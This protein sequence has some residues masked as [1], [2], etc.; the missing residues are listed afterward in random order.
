MSQYEITYILRPLLE[1]P[2][3]DEQVMHFSDVVKNNGGQISNAER[4]GKKRLAYE[5]QKQREGHY[6]CMQFDGNPDCAKE[7][8]RQ[9]RLAESVIR[10]MLI[11]R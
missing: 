6:V 4:L 7:A 9:L 5:I 8:L 3:V 1:D 10:A 2:Q 11:K